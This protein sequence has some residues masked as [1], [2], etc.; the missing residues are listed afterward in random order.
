MFRIK[1]KKIIILK[2]LISFFGVSTGYAEPSIET[3]KFGLWSLIKVVPT[4]GTL[5]G[6]MLS[7]AK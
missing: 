4:E 6:G 3:T 5:G 7:R 1:T 2:T